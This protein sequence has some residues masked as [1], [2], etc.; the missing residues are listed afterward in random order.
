LLD[1]ISADL[2]VIDLGLAAQQFGKVMMGARYVGGSDKVPVV[3]DDRRFESEAEDLVAPFRPIGNA[4]GV[5]R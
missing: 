1:V 2:A 5:W 4:A 3:D